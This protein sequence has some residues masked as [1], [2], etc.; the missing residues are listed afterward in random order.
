MAKSRYFYSF[1]S[2]DKDKNFRKYDSTLYPKIEH[3]EDDIIIVSKSGDR[4]DLL[5]YQYYGDVTLWWVIAQANQL[6]KGTLNVPAG[7][8]LH[9][10]QNLDKIYA[11]L[12]TINRNR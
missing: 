8:T 7:T 10:P 2:K 6:G 5:A 3:E 1:E 4:F 9:I 12:D 11:K